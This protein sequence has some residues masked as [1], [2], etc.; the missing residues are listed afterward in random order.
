MKKI[1]K[2]FM[3]IAI[4]GIAYLSFSFVNKDLNSFNWDTEIRVIYLF[5]SFIICSFPPFWDEY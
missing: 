2:I 5:I 3:C 1:K 4:F